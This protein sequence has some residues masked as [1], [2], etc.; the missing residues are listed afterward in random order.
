MSALGSPESAAPRTFSGVSSFLLVGR[1]GP[2]SGWTV[3]VIAGHL[4]RTLLEDRL[5]PLLPQNHTQLLGK[6]WD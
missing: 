1:P 5:R 3:E 2:A 4:L 6:A